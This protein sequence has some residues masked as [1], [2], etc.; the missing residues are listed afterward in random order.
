MYKNGD[1]EEWPQKK[2]EWKIETKKVQYFSAIIVGLSRPLKLDS[3]PHKRP[4]LLKVHKKLPL[5]NKI[6]L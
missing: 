1:V 3:L 4:F 5:P 2:I 6:Q